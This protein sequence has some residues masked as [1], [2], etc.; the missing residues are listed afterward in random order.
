MPD[1]PHPEL[2]VAMLDLYQQ[3]NAIVTLHDNFIDRLTRSFGFA[4]AIHYIH[5]PNATSGFTKLWEKKRLDLSVEAL[6]LQ[7]QWY[8]L[9]DE[10]DLRRAYGRLSDFHFNFPASYWSPNQEPTPSIDPV[11]NVRVNYVV[12][13]EYTR[14]AIYNLL[15]LPNDQ[16]GGDWLNGYHRHASDFYI[17]CNIGVAGRT[18][19]DYD[20]HWD[21]E[22]LVWFGKSGS[23]F[24]QSTIQNLISGDYRILIFYREADRDPFKFAGVG[25]PVPH[26]ESSRPVRVD[27]VFGSEDSEHVP[28]FTDEYTAGA[29]FSEGQRTK[30]YVN[31]YERDRR[32]RDKCV[33]FHGVN[34]AVCKINFG[35]FYGEIGEGYIHV[36]HITPVSALGDTCAVDPVTDLVP[37]CPNCHAMLHRTNPPLSVEDLRIRLANR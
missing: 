15:D 9:F 20:N 26:L 19:H 36:H 17:F 6:I 28:F 5:L 8:M 18:G 31:R 35:E 24:N 13:K 4:T 34:C 7:P 3:A 30:V 11:Q 29:R 37:V 27:W 12:G 14:N 10:A 21:G 2:T 23:H 33:Q 16:R 25:T 1:D 32:A 22:R